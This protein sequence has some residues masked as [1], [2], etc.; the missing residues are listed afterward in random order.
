[1]VRT[2]I[3]SI[4]LTS[5]YSFSRTRARYPR[6]KPLGEVRLLRSQVIISVLM[7]TLVPPGIVNQA[8]VND[9]NVDFGNAQY[10]GS[11]SFLLMNKGL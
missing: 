4:P 3:L 10:N 2:F 1:M 5:S 7:P 11:R 9:S 6:M 8:G